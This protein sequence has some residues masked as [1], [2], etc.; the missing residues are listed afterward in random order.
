[1]LRTQQA[2]PKAHLGNFL[3]NALKI[4]RILKTADRHRVL[5]HSTGGINDD[6]DGHASSMRRRWHGHRGNEHAVGVWDRKLQRD[7]FGFE[8]LRWTGLWMH[9]PDRACTPYRERRDTGQRI[10]GH[11][12]WAI[13]GVLTSKTSTARSR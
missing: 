8:R 4:R 10:A 6:A 7:T 2:G 9:D 11:F 1:M 5:H 3:G 13:D 12:L